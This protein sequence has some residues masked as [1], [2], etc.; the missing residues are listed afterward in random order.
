VAEGNKQAAILNAEGNRQAAILNAEGNRQ[1]AIL[2]AEGFSM[3]LQRIFEVAQTLDA[4]T[5]SLQYLEALKQIGSS[6]STKFVVPLE[7]SNLLAGVTGLTARS[8]GD[9]GRTPPDA[10]G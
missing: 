2:N 7:L 9:G 10:R 4:N 8:F 6:P 1:A 3:A 5:M